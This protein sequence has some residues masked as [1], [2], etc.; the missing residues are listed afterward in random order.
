MLAIVCSLV[1]GF[2]DTAAAETV[3]PRPVLYA[4]DANNAKV[5][6]I[7]P[8]TEQIAGAIAVGDQPVAIAL[9][10]DGMRA[11]VACSGSNTV[12]VIDTASNTP[13]ANVAV[14]IEPVSIAAARDGSKV[15]VG[16]LRSGP[17]SVIDTSTNTLTPLGAFS[18]A[19]GVL[20]MA[21]SA[22]GRHLYTTNPFS[23]SVNRVDTVSGA[24]TRLRFNDQTAGI[25]LSPDDSRAYVAVGFDV[26]TID[27]A[28]M[29]VVSTVA[30]TGYAV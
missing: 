11:Y 4:T 1:T 2:A 20:G 16:N 25:A 14:G 9:S 8:L 29:T 5:V 7:D 19:D 28:T 26:V 15:F 3:A 21:L 13:L 12:T 22:D 27:T 23:L 30:T 17:I 18:G 24:V 6:L 10:P